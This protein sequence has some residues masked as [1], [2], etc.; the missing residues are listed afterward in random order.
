MS[1]YDWESAEF[2]LPSAAV[3]AVKKALRDATNLLHE[4]AKTQAHAFWAQH[5]TTS[6]RRYQERLHEWV[7]SFYRPTSYNSH[8]HQFCGPA[9]LNESVICSIHMLLDDHSQRPHKLTVAELSQ[10]FPKATNRTTTFPIGEG[11]I[12]IDGRTLRWQIGENNHACDKAYSHPVM[13]ALMKA[14]DAVKWTRGTGGR[15]WGSDEYA[16][17]AARDHGYDPVS[18]KREWGPHINRPTPTRGLHAWR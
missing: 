8:I 9:G 16:I 10:Y 12:V 3:P 7:Q 17:E 6:S 15:S 5:K 13:K 4:Q 18:T 1:R 11:A 14:L 2:V